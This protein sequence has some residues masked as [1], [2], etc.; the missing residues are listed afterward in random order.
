MIKFINKVL[1]RALFYDRW[2]CNVCNKEIFEGYFCKDC[3]SKITLI[4]ENKCLHCGRLTPYA[5]NYCNSCAEKNIN[6][7]KALSVFNYEP[8]VSYLIQNFKYQNQK[9]LGDYFS[10]ELFNLYKKANLTCDLITFI[11]M[12]PSR[13][14][15]RGYNHAEILSQKFSVLSGKQVVSCVKKTKET[16]RQ[17]TLSLSKRLKNLSSSFQV[18]KALVKGKSILLI[19]DVLTTGAT[20]DTASKLLKKAGAKRVTVLTVASV[21]KTEKTNSN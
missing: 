21:S 18:D 2:T 9:Y 15:E 6:F 3:Q 4:S 10:K 12:H 8:P 1:N 16:E 7:D 13:L 19:D 11:P 14:E 20:A 5:V 17:A